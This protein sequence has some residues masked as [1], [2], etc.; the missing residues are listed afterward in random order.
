MPLPLAEI[1]SYPAG[2]LVTYCTAVVL[3]SVL[4]GL[5]PEWLRLTH[6]GMQFLISLVG[7][8]M[9]GIAIFHMIPHA[10]AQLGPN[11]SDQLAWGMMFGLL[12]TFFLLRFFHFHQHGPAD[13]GTG[14]SVAETHLCSEHSHAIH[15]VVD[16]EPV[17]GHDRA[18]SDPPAPA[19]KSDHAHAHAQ[20]ESPRW[21]GVL[22]GLG[23]HTLLDGMA[24]AASVKAEQ[25]HDH[26]QGHW[27]I[28]FGTF[29]A[30]FLHKPLDAISIT[31][32][33]VNASPDRRLLVNIGFA[34][35]CP[36]GAFAFWAGADVSGSVAVMAGLALAFSAGVF[37]CI[38]LSDL[39][40]EMEFHSHNRIRLTIALLVGIFIAWAIGLFEAD[41]LP[42]EAEPRRSASVSWE[43]GNEETG[44]ALLRGRW[45]F[46]KD[47]AT[48]GLQFSHLLAF[49]FIAERVVVE[50][51]LPEWC[52][53]FA[54]IGF[55]HFHQHG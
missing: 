33:M 41:S 18:A 2:L 38:S 23:L 5:I 43:P 12:S 35:M 31:S 6:V 42:C 48:H 44:T 25:L 27:L 13:F 7:G 49:G 34:L 29:L 32:L 20:H 3:A 17:G 16:H 30:V 51:D 26:G 28:G 24:L 14:E 45:L 40:P 22:L 39:L 53:L 21:I 9:L 10:A 54:T 19:L 46:Q 11:R 47:A 36:V 37:L 50:I 55:G 1:V 4:G 52:E 15:L 8:V